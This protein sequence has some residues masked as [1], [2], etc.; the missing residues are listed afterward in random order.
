MQMTV[1]A[2]SCSFLYPFDLSL[3]NNE[4]YNVSSGAS[5]PDDITEDL[6]KAE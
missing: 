3:D 4:L 6:L 1:E 5:I 2:F